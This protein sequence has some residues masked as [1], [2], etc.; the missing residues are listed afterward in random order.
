MNDFKDKVMAKLSQGVILKCEDCN[1]F[2]KAGHMI[3]DEKG[4]VKA[5]CPMCFIMKYE[6]RVRPYQPKDQ[7]EL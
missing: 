5:V 7:E 6:G 1:C 2:G 4:E 3:V